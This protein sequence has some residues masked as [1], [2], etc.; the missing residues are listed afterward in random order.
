[1]HRVASPRTQNLTMLSIV[2][3]ISAVTS[4]IYRVHP[5]AMVTLSAK[6]DEEAHNS[7]G[8]IVFTSLFPYMFIVT[9]NVW[10]VTSKINKACSL[11]MVNTRTSAEFD[12]EAHNSLVSIVFT[13]LFQYIS[14]VTLTFHLWPPK[15]IGSILFLWLIYLPSSIK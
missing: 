9:L 4:K 1:M 5:L 12:E 2:T 7:L 10:P 8:S 11:T 14:I 6:F 3:R 15:S 13:S